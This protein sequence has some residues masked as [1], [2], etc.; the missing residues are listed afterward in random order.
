M[1]GLGVTANHVTVAAMGLS[2]AT[3]AALAFFPGHPKLLLAVPGV[4]FAR[5]ALNAIDGM[6]AREFG[7]QSD[8]GALLNELGDVISD[9]GLYLPLAFWPGFTPWLV[10]GI[11]VLAIIS[12]MTGV[13][14]QTLGSPRGYAGPMGK[15]DRAFLFSVICTILGCGTPPGMWIEGFLLPAFL[16]LIAT[17]LNRGR[18]ALK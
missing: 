7:H 4:L 5:M 15:S 6:L 1:N 2:L 18:Q 9:A 17:I 12:E 8:L 10:V 13:L 3:G 14:A 11:V 16:L